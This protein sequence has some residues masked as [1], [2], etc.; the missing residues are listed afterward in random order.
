MILR[1]CDHSF[2]LRA[3]AVK[4]AALIGSAGQGETANGER[5]FR[6]RRAGAHARELPQRRMGG[7]DASEAFCSRFADRVILRR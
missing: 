7:G 4:D 2:P 3:L 5:R 6:M 1:S